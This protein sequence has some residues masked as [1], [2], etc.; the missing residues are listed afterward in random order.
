MDCIN[1]A[2]LNG[3]FPDELKLVDM[4]PLYK[5]S[6]LHDKPNANRSSSCNQF[7]RSMERYI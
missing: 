1:S 2:I 3:V 5:K 6:D 7:P 4:R